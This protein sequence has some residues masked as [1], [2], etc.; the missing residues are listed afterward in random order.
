MMKN[1]MKKRDLGKYAH[2]HRGKSLRVMTGCATAFSEI[3]H[4]AIVNIITI[5]IIVMNITR[6]FGDV[7]IRDVRGGA[8]SSG[9]GRG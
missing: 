1:M 3:I 2:V 8:F 4:I 7:G 5:I 9:A 6:T